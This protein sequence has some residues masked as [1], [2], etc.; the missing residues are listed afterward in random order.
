MVTYLIDIARNFRVADFFDISI[1]S[2]LT[3]A[4]LIWF[5]RTASRF[6]LIG[7]SILGLVYVLARV[8]DLYL[9]VFV[10]QGFFAVL[11]IAL[12]IIFQEDLRLFFERL[13]RW[14][15]MRT[16]WPVLPSAKE[17]DVLIQTV[18]N[19]AQK[20]FGALIVL[21]GRDY[22]E[23][24]L[25]GGIALEGKVSEAL[26]ESL[27]DPH[28]VGH[29]GAAIIV[30]DRVVKFG[31]RL[32]LSLSMR[33]I[34][35][36]GLRHTAALGLAERSDALVVVVSEER[37]TITVAREGRL[38]KLENIDQL[39]TI[40]DHFYREREPRA[41]KKTWFG[42]WGK[43]PW[44]KVIAVVFACGL[45]LAFGYQAESIR[46]GFVVPIEYRNLPPDWFI[47]EPRAKEATVT[48]MGS[49]QAFDLLNPQTLKIVLDMSKIQEGKQELALKP[50]QVRHPSNLSVAG[51]E[52]SKIDLKIHKM[53]VF[54]APIKVQTSGKLP[55]G[56]SLRHITV[57]PKSIQVMGPSHTKKRAQILTEPINLQ[58]ITA[59]TILASKLVL[60][61]NMRFV[62]DTPPTVQVT[63]EIEQRKSPK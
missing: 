8:F 52:P 16:R 51:I 19:L 36:L 48:L 4:V 41:K 7:I 55:P 18:A 28:S 9:T 3:Y 2:V 39:K 62:N 59:T 53:V 45:W 27:F 47:E 60:P 49:G 25:Q 21:R 31:C 56:V 14:G 35:N 26:L 58:D 33:K 40:L 15:G 30:D 32:P 57:E 13:A 11:L 20:R 1:I 34:G 44:E 5:R 61:S 23:R 17:I 42:R 10:F 6:V 22:L 37:G 12:I 29:D 50:D 54:D 24:H 46:R 38:R 43:N 63:V